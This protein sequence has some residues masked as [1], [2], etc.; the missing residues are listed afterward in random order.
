MATKTVERPTAGTLAG[1]AGAVVATGI[2]TVVAAGLVALLTGA[3]WVLRRTRRRILPAY[4]AGSAVVAAA[5]VE[6][7]GLPLGLVAL[8][9]LAAALVAGGWRT[10]RFEVRVYRV[11]VAAV[12]GLWVLN[13]A[14]AGSLR[15][16]VA[17][18]PWVTLVVGWPWWHWLRTWA[19]PVLVEPEP[20]VDESLTAEWV[21]RWKARVVDEGVCAG[22]RVEDAASPRRHVVEL[23]LRLS[24]GS[25]ISEVATQADRVDT[26]L[27][28]NEGSSGFSRTGKAAILT[29]IIAE[30]SYIADTVPYTGPVVRDGAVRVGVFADG[31]PL[32]WEMLRPKFGALP[33]LGVGSIGSGKSRAVDVLVDGALALGIPV[34]VGDPQNGQSLPDWNGVVAEYHSGVEATNALIDRLHAEVMERSDRLGRAGVTAYDQHDPRVVALDITPLMVFIDEVHLVLVGTGTKEQRATVLKFAQIVSTARKTG[35]G[36]DV[37]TQIPQ[38]GSLGGLQAIRDALTSFNCLVLRLSNNGSKCT[39]LPPDFVGDPM[40]IPEKISGR[41]TAGMGYAKGGDRIGM[42]ARVPFIDGAKAAATAP[43]IP[44]RW[45]V[46]APGV[47]T[48]QSPTATASPSRPVAPVS[49]MADR[50]KASFGLG[51]PVARPAPS[52]PPQSSAAGNPVLAGEVVDTPRWILGALTRA[53][54]SAQALLDRP[55]CPVSQA[56]LYTRLNALAASGVLVK[57]PQGGVWQIAAAG[58]RRDTA[59]TIDLELVV[60][61]AELV[62][63]SQFGST[64]MVGRKLRIG[65]AMSCAV[66][67]ELER[68]D[69][70]GPADGSKARDV[71]I[72]PDGLD[73]L[74]DTIRQQPRP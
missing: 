1:A 40:A 25:K 45:L 10:G 28:L 63:T 22:T 43:R 64:S 17:V 27:D 34:I 13:V 21:E 5:I 57:P 20:V 62:I 35:V 61:A 3:V 18:L 49:S 37:D 31:S 12:F 39:I 60:G 55:D 29:L 11:T 54:Q 59:P 73:A 69:V 51:T 44:F 72:K 70:V 74:L 23:R 52:D 19:P 30:R 42:L 16:G 32:W 41:S 47:A 53:P 24:P 38:L 71:L 14:A 9:V 36:V 7:A 2:L 56:Q 67:D 68:L 65:F 33:G 50:I 8:G 4:W 15:I 48:T 58:Q 46:P 66:M 6:A 26:A